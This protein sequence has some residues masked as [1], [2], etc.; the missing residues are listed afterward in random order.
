MVSISFS[1]ELVTI[2]F[3]ARELCV[4][5]LHIN[6][7]IENIGPVQPVWCRKEKQAVSKE[8]NKGE[9]REEVI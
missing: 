9:I 1:L 6:M 3:P 7:H 2:P 8:E 4:P 5:S